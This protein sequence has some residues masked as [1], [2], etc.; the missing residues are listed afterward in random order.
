MKRQTKIQKQRE[1]PNQ[2]TK[3]KRKAKQQQQFF[4]SSQTSD[5]IA[6]KLKTCYFSGFSLC[7]YKP[8]KGVSVI[9]KQK[10]SKYTENEK[11]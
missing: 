11:H 5:K 4:V 10:Q 1:K 2:N 3:T 9:K 8:E 7:H 6:Q